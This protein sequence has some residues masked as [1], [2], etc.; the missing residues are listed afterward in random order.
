MAREPTVGREMWFWVYEVVGIRTSPDTMLVLLLEQQF[1]SICDMNGK[2]WVRLAIILESQPWSSLN[3]PKLSKGKGQGHHPS[4][5]HH[6]GWY[7][8]LSQQWTYTFCW[9]GQ[10]WFPTPAPCDREVP[11][12]TEH[13][14]V[15]L[16]R[17]ETY[18]TP[19]LGYGSHW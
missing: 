19:H 16:S 6:G 12:Q 17:T 18:V 15:T 1:R 11:W 5:T 8:Y 10:D 14:C 4:L 3:H 9:T 7:R 2:S 13:C